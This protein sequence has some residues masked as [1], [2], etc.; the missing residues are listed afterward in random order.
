MANE[1]EFDKE[2]AEAE[3][4]LTADEKLQQEL[5]H[6]RE[7]LKIGIRRA[8]K[9]RKFEEA[10]EQNVERRNTAPAGFHK[11][12]FDAGCHLCQLGSEYATPEDREKV[13]DVKFAYLSGMK[14]TEIKQVFGVLPSDVKRHARAH[15]WYYDKAKATEFGWALILRKGL[16]R[17]ASGQETIDPDQVIEAL[18]HLDKREGKI[19]DISKTDG[20]ITIRLD[21]GGV[22]QPQPARGIATAEANN[23]KQDI[24]L[25]APTSVTLIEEVPSET[26]AGAVVNQDGPKSDATGEDGGNQT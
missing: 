1:N 16:A 15:N 14:F 9:I 12:G 18:K 6:G 25:L 10:S 3:A 24:K 8:R 4:E 13:K 11:E 20:N 22:P 23:L 17:I 7:K 26:V 5:Q 21:T 19:V 2:N